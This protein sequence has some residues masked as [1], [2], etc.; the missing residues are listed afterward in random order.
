MSVAT[1][2][3]F[4]DSAATAFRASGENDDAGSVWMAVVASAV[5]S[6][7]FAASALSSSAGST[8]QKERE[9]SVCVC[10]REYYAF[11]DHHHPHHQE[12]VEQ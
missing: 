6:T 11:S 9:G 10:V 4:V 7:R 1:V 5:S 3:S 8:K 2:C 12:Q